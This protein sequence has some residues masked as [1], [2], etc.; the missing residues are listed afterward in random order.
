MQPTT[1]TTD[2][3]RQIW[4]RRCLVFP[5]VTGPASNPSQGP[6]APLGQVAGAVVIGVVLR[7]INSTRK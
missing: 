6:I 2:L 1:T 5:S 7:L 4:S 3:S